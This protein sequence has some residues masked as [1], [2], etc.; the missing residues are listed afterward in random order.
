MIPDRYI[1]HDMRQAKDFNKLTISGYKKQDV[2]IAFQNSMINNKIEDSIR[3]LVE[4][5]SSGMESNIWPSL[6]LLVTKYVHINN[7]KLYIYFN[8]RFA[9]YEAILNKY[10]P[11]LQHIY[12]RN[13][14]EIRNMLA[15][16]TSICCLT[17]KNNIFLSNSMPKLGKNFLEKENLSKRMLSKDLYDIID[18]CY[19]TTTNEMKLALNEILTNIRSNKGTFENC[20][21]WYLWLEKNELIR[22]KDIGKSA[23]SEDINELWT[24]I[25]WKIINDH[26]HQ[27]DDSN[28]IFIKKLHDDYMDNFKISSINKKKYLI[29]IVFYTFKKK[30]NWG[31]SLY[32]QEYILLQVLG[33]INRMYEKIKNQNESKLSQENKNILYTNFNKIFYKKHENTI[34]PEKR[35]E[36]IA[37]NG[38]NEESNEIIFT[39]YPEY[40]QISKNRIQNLEPVNTRKPTITERYQQPKQVQ[41]IDQSKTERYNNIYDKYSRKDNYKDDEDDY[42]SIDSIDNK[43]K[44]IRINPKS[45]SYR[46]YNKNDEDDEDD[47]DNYN[48]KELIGKKVTNEDIIN[49]KEERMLMKI[50]AFKQLVTKRNEHDGGKKNNLSSNPYEDFKSIDIIKKRKSEM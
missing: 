29:F 9:E 44:N 34:V 11:K 30:I 40:H 35:P 27:L 19:D 25:I 3:W 33:N 4:L 47:E 23:E 5:H 2:V 17:K 13:N 42:C 31:I 43:E 38:L 12:S 20:L 50:D 21:Y 1:I 26:K 16:L 39:K 14:Q 41:F 37:D 7:P 48:Q 10:P 15:E 22:K 36:R 46:E 18:Y 6:Y 49:A 45:R 28:K 32:Q 24:I 8:K